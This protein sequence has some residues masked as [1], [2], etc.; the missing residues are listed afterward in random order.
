VNGVVGRGLRLSGL[1][2]SPV[3]PQNMGFFDHKET[4]QNIEELKDEEI[5]SLSKRHPHLFEIL[6]ARYEEALLRKAIGILKNREEAEDI[7]Q[8]AFTKIYINAHRFEVVEGASFKSWA[9]R[10]LINT[11]FTRYQKL[12]RERGFRAHLDPEIYE[13]FGDFKTRDFEK[14]EVSE[15]VFSVLSR[16]PEHLSRVLYLHIIEGRPQEEV[17]EIEGVSV[18]AVKTRVHRA[19]KA[20]K[21]VDIALI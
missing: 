20:F 3:R 17:A 13:S 4:D 5:L 14:Q 16:I 2:T 15:Y 8:E 7:V 12:K 21:N 6:I 1:R 11:A 9:Y 18:G 10:I 19:K